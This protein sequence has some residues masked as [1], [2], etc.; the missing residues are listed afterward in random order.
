MDYGN[1]RV[2]KLRFGRDLS[3]M[4]RIPD[5][6][7]GGTFSKSSGRTSKTLGIITYYRQIKPR[8][9][10]LEFFFCQ[11]ARV[12]DMERA[13]GPIKFSLTVTWLMVDVQ[14]GY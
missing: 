3:C 8:K 10:L 4:F 9:L 6:S 14:F 5:F 11:L 2:I 7:T 12:C 1:G 13:A